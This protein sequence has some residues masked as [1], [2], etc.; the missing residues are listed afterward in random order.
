MRT[1]LMF[2]ELLHKLRTFSQS[3]DNASI[4]LVYVV[5][6]GH[7]HGDKN[8]CFLKTAN[9]ASL[10]EFEVWTNCSRLFGQS[11]CFLKDKPKLVF[12]QICRSEGTLLYIMSMILIYLT[13]AFN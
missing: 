13:Y 10:R 1:V 2:Q 6:M 8:N 9:S 3:L 11:S 7:G 12:A 4:D 5:F